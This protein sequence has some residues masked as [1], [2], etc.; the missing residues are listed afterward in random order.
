MV[1]VEHVAAQQEILLLQQADLLLQRDEELYEVVAA[2]NLT[3]SAAVAPDLSPSKSTSNETLLSRSRA[4]AMLSSSSSRSRSLAGSSSGAWGGPGVRGLGGVGGAALREAGAVAT[5]RAYLA[6]ESS[7]LVLAHQRAEDICMVLGP[8]AES[9]L[10]RD[11][12]PLEQSA[13]RP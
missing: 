6:P 8:A 13:A 10:A 5:G 7:A 9:G 3:T 4:L 11:L 12:A 2:R 1:E